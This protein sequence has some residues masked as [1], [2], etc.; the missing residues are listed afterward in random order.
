MPI[1]ASTSADQFGFWDAAHQGDLRRLRQMI[2]GGCNVNG[3][4]PAWK[5][6]YQPTALAYAVWGNQ[7][8]AIKLLLD[9]GADPDRV[10]GVRAR[11]PNSGTQNALSSC[12]HSTIPSLLQ[13]MVPWCLA[14]KSVL[15]DDLFCTP[16]SDADAP[17]RPACCCCARRRTATTTRCTG[18][19]TRATT[20]SAPRS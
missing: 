2:D 13:R 11:S 20:P 17:R 5:S 18:R 4:C 7:L 9:S 12:P 14:E 8:D 15:P 10:D 6:A 19:R 16:F 3:T 1:A